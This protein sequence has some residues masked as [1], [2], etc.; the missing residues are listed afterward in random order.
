[1]LC[2]SQAAAFYPTLCAT[3]HVPDSYRLA[4][5]VEAGLRKCRFG[6]SSGLPS[7][8]TSVGDERDSMAHLRFASHR[9]HP[10]CTHHSPLASSPGEGI[11]Q[12]GNAR[13][14]V[15]SWSRELVRVADL[16][17]WRCL[18]FTRTNLLLVPSV[19]MSTAFPVAG[20]TIWNSL[21][22]NVTSALSLSTFC[23]H[24]K[25]LSS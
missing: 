20:P 10:V 15:S 21:P 18:R 12:H 1:M 25:T 22:D 16:P 9:P 23:Q 17:G 3:D 8:P 14:Q 13:V 11:V 24:M 2:G 7:S 6:R 19:K 5:S 4:G